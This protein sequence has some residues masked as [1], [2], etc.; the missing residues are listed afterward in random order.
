MTT[1]VP[2]S[3]DPATE[4]VPIQISTAA[5]A[6]PV[7]M[8]TLFR[9]DDREYQIP[10]KPR[11]NLALQQLRLVRELGP[12]LANVGLLEELL[13]PDTFADLANCNTLTREQLGLVSLAAMRLT[14]GPLEEM[15]S[16]N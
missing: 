14:M 11:A 10:A 6:E 5:P 2:Q 9:I 7:E 13:G 1:P 15:A 16:G 12:E 8:V 3:I 4:H